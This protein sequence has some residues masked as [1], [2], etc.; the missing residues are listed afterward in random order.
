[1]AGQDPGNIGTACYIHLEWMCWPS[2]GLLEFD[3][4][5]GLVNLL[6]LVM[7]CIRYISAGRSVT[8]SDNGPLDI[9]KLF[10]LSMQS[11]FFHQK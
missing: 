9:I 7:S 11:L 10:F 1:M 3:D 8:I 2:W 6:K 4:F 5:S